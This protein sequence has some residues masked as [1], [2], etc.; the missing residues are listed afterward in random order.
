VSRGFEHAAHEVLRV[1]LPRVS[2]N[3]RE[4]AGH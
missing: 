4:Q 1:F 2:S 3:D